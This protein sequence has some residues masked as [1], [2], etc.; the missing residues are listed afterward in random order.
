MSPHVFAVAVALATMTFQAPVR[1]AERAPDGIYVIGALHALHEKERS[2]GYDALRES[3]ERIDPDLLVIEVTDDELQSRGETKGRP[4]YPAVVWPFLQ[5]RDVDAAALEPSGVEYQRLIGQAS[6][7]MKALRERAPAQAS[8][9]T[10][11]QKALETVLLAHWDSPS[12]THDDVTGDL[13]RA[14]YVVQSATLGPDYV[15][16]QA[17]WDARMAQRAVSAIRQSRAGR[18]VVLGSYRNRHVLED[19][20]RKAFPERVVDVRPFLETTASKP[21]RP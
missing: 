17:A 9:W 5:S 14:W 12:A 13:A 7:H 16:I 19:A 6:T 20:L 8:W 2:F 10:D 21:Q 11:Y 1:A 18:I 4:E 3:L 15:P